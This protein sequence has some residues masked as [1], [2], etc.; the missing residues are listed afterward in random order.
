M[1]QQRWDG[2]ATNF[3]DGETLTNRLAIIL[4]FM[5]VALFVIDWAFFDGGL[6]VF[7]GS[8]F[9]DFVEYVAFWR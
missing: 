5:V 1:L 3:T 8:K 4:G 7:L 9:A 2:S 6:P